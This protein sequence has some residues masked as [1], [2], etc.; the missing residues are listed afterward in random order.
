MRGA[1]ATQNSS[2]LYFEDI[3]MKTGCCTAKQNLT[4][5]SSSRVMGGHCVKQTN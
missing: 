4:L 3:L 2:Q 5:S 1:V